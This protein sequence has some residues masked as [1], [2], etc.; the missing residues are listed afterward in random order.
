A[1]MRRAPR[2][3]EVIS[4]PLTATRRQNWSRLLPQRT[5]GAAQR[6]SRAYDPRPKIAAMASADRAFDRGTRVGLRHLGNLGADLRE[7]RIELGLSQQHVAD[8]AHLSR[9]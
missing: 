7:R 9:S 4:P 6:I 3:A 5:C 2:L 1:R 8:A